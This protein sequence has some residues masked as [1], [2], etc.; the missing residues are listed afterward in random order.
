MG[1]IEHVWRDLDPARVPTDH[2]R[3]LLLS[4]VSA[5]LEP[6]LRSQV[7]SVVIDAV[8]RCGCSSVRLRSDQAAIPPSRV[9]ELSSRQRPDY[10]AV[11]ASGEGPRHAGVNVVLHVSGGRAAE[12]E[13]F[14]SIRGEGAAVELGSLISL[15][16]PSIN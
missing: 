8:C 16:T 4:L 11:E 6:L 13:I 15:T 14:D 9:A 12:L 7:S 5:V 3:R 1:A 10:F 2:E